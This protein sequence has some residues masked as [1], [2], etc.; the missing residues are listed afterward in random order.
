MKFLAW[1]HTVLVLV[2]GLKNEVEVSY[3]SVKLAKNYKVIFDTQKCIFTLQDN[4]FIS[5]N[6]LLPSY[7]TGSIRKFKGF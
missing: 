5:S 6:K 2:L 3:N 7:H 1:L 4:W